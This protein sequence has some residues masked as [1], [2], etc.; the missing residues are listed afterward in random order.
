MNGKVT[1]MRP[2]RRKTWYTIGV[3]A[4]ITWSV[5]LIVPWMTSSRASVPRAHDREPPAAS[6]ARSADGESWEGVETLAQSPGGSLR[7]SVTAARAAGGSDPVSDVEPDHD[8][9]R[10]ARE[11]KERASSELV[12]GEGYLPDPPLVSDSPEGETEAAARAR[13]AT[14]ASN[15]PPAEAAPRQPV[16]RVLRLLAADARYVLEPEPSPKGAAGDPGG[17]GVPVGPD[18]ND[19]S[20]AGPRK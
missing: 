8:D 3:A 12:I 14:L 1:Q 13:K 6:A 17:N 10:A 4:A 5:I 16:A 15:P 20:E 19:D 18:G 2:Q 9:V 7:S 11:E